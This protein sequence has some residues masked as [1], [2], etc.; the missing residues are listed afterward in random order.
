MN[1]QCSQSPK[2]GQNVQGYIYKR[3]SCFCKQICK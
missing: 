1:N 3:H 2:S